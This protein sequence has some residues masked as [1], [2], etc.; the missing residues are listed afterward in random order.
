MAVMAEKVSMGGKEVR[1]RGKRRERKKSYT[2]PRRTWFMK[3]EASSSRTRDPEAF[4][5]E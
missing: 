2:S 3:R 1:G 5:S 4:P